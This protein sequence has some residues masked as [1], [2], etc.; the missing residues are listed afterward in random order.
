MRHRKKV[1]KLSRRE[2]D[3][4]R[5]LKNLASS[6]IIYEKVK[7]TRAK[8]KAVQPIVEH[9]ITISKKKDKLTARRR[10]LAYLPEKNATAKL[11]E[12]LTKKYKDK[13]SGFTRI[14]KLGPRRG[15]CADMVY[16]ELI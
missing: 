3:R 1:K 16:V 14:T 5:L 12:E 13:K 4:S 7:T 6:V 9:L 2:G 11:M 10:L 8:A 15:D